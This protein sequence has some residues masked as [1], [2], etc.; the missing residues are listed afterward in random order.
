ML[1]LPD[2]IA[3]VPERTVP[4]P[5]P[6]FRA[7]LE[8]FYEPPLVARSTSKRVVQVLRELEALGITTTA[9]L[10]PPLI[11][12]YIAS[13]PA[14]QSAYTLKGM[15]GTV[16]VVCSYAEQMGYVRVSPFRLRRM[17]RWTGPMPP[18]GNGKARHN[19]KAEIKAVWALAAADVETRQGWASWRARRTQVAFCL[20]SLMGLRKNEIFRLQ[21]GDVDLAARIIWVR[22]HG[23]RLKTAASRAPLPIPDALVPI[24]TSW[25]AH[26]MDAP[27]GYPLPDE[28]PWFIPT[29]SRKSPWVSGSSSSKPLARLRELARRAGVEDMTW[30]ML[31]RSAATHL[32]AHG[33]GRALIKRILRHTSERTSEEFYSEADMPN[34]LNAVGGFCY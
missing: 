31:R 22:P 18:K 23:K 16:R 20:A 1:T 34:L 3:T 29:A 2:D 27:F 14:G 10:T 17:S 13:R 5:W 12:R 9:D 25:L 33:V 4:I 19:T 32:E 11:V 28:C 30:Q 15:L 6:Q 8:L 26:R 21:V 7:E 24:L